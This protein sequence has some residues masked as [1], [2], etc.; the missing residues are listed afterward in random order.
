MIAE[1]GVDTLRASPTKRLGLQVLATIGLVH[2]AM[3]ACYTMPNLIFGM[4]A[5][6][7]PADVQK[8]SY[9]TDYICGDGTDRAC[10]GPAIPNLR[11]DNPSGGSGSFWV[12]RDGGLG[13]PP[14]A[15]LPPAIPFEK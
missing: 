3:F 8:R 1:R 2:V 6:E 12:T 5:R 11:N 13:R 9:L 10:P 7:W 14:Q 15:P 4:N